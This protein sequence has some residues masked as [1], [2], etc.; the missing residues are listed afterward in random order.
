M[1]IIYQ[2]YG[3]THSSIACSYIH[4]G[5]LPV[6]RVPRVSELIKLPHFDR[7]RSIEIGKLNY[8][9]TDNSGNHVYAMGSAGDSDEIREIL[10]DILPVVGIT[11]EIKII[12]CLDQVN[13]LARIGGFMSRQLGMV[14]I[15]RPL[16][17]LGIKL[18]Y[19]A[20]VRKA[21]LVMGQIP[22]LELE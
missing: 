2:C 10:Y 21:A 15:G 19:K 16:A 7:L 13:T 14:C 17:A 12:N 20:L 9:G 3:S 5:K 11:D 22:P 18:R 1:L 4:L 8:I 6:H